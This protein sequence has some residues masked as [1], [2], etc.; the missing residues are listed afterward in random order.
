MKKTLITLAVLFVVCFGLGFIVSKLE[1]K[2]GWVEGHKPYGIYE[3]HVKRPL[4]F[5][6]AVFTL[7]LFWP[8]FLAI[9][10][11]VRINM[12]SPIVFSQKRPGLGGK[13]FTIKK[14]RTMTDARDSEGNLLP[15]EK[16]L[17]RFGK[18]LRSSSG[19]EGLELVSIA[20]GDLSFVGPRPL[21]VEYLPR[22]SEE[23][24]HRHDVR[25]GLTGYAQVSGRNSISWEEKFKGDL[26]YVDHISFL[27]DLK[28]FLKTF[29][30]VFKRTGINS[31]TNVTMEPF[32]GNKE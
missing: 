23:Q 8:I 27:T 6:V 15:D 24:M 5:A 32:A 16:R 29:S 18:L 9:A 28:I 31:D 14:F 13:I 10:I 30:V 7:L 25:P 26:W 20:R 19:D 21:L 17:T 2:K 3:R 22:Y 1:K 12:G 4:D 11:A